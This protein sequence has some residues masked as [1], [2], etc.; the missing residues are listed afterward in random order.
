MIKLAVLVCQPDTQVITYDHADYIAVDGGFHALQN[1]DI[2][3]SALIGDL[4]SINSY[5]YDGIII[6]YDTMKDETDTFLAIKYAK[7]AGYEKIIIQGVTTH[8]MDHFLNVIQLL[9]VFN[10]LDIEIIDGCN[11]I[12]LLHGEQI[13]N[14]DAKY[15]SFFSLNNT[16][17]NTY[18]LLYELEDY[19]I[20]PF[21]YQSISNQIISHPCRV[22]TSNPL[23]VLL[24]H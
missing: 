2:T 11:R 4:D 21:T 5:N 13:I 22:H 15:I 20:T 1:Y 14:T 7:E 18:G 23:V 24:S 9:Y 10:T 8:R 17:V 19:A 6:K 3:C 16:I 12:F